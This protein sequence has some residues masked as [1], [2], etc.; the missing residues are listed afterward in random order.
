MSVPVD[1]TALGAEIERFGAVAFLVTASPDG[2][3]HV[4]SV[5]V[6]FAGGRL[7]MPAGRTARRNVTDSSAATL[8]WSGVPGDAYC[9]LVDGTARLA[10]DED[11]VITVDPTSAVLHRLADAPDD[12]PSC[13]PVDGVE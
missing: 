1:L 6:T 3:P 8:L 5:A 12:L 2:R 7:T 13:V 9:L 10:G 4:V 11:E